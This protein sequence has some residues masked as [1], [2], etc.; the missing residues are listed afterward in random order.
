MAFRLISASLVVGRAKIHFCITVQ[1]FGVDFPG[2][3]ALIVASEGVTLAGA[4]ESED[5]VSDPTS[6]AVVAVPSS[7]TIGSK[8][9]HSPSLRATP[10]QTD[11]R[12]KSSGLQTRPR[13]NLYMRPLWKRARRAGAR[14]C[15]ESRECDVVSPTSY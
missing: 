13:M 6:V 3:I 5:S 12:R 9:C 7:D 2:V 8:A 1:R 4:N 11:S 15:W 14:L 10:R